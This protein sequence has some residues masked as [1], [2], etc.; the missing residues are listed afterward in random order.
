MTLQ[1][2][3]KQVQDDKKKVRDY[4]TPLF[5]IPTPLRH[6]ENVIPDP[7]CT[8]QGRSDPGSVSESDPK[9]RS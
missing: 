8:E 5:V 3:L 4:D 7:A 1:L 2:I 6:S 9:N